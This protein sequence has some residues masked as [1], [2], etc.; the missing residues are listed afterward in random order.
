MGV[1]VITSFTLASTG[2]SCNDNH[3]NSVWSD[4]INNREQTCV[5]TWVQAEVCSGP[6]RSIYVQLLE[7]GQKS[8]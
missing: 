3:A 6:D 7:A 1:A 2:S 5:P 4:P 8:V